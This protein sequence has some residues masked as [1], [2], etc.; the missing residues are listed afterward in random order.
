MPSARRPRVGSKSTGP[1]DSSAGKLDANFS[2]EAWAGSKC[3]ASEVMFRMLQDALLKMQ[4]CKAFSCCKTPS[5]P[6][7]SMRF[8]S[9]DKNLYCSTPE[10]CP[11]NQPALVVCAARLALATMCPEETKDDWAPERAW[12]A[13]CTMRSLLSKSVVNAISCIKSLS[14]EIC[15]AMAL[16]R[17]KRYA[18]GSLSPFLFMQMVEAEMPP[19]LMPTRR[20]RLTKSPFAVPSCFS[21]RV[22]SGTSGINSSGT[23]ER[24]KATSV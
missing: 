21:A 23:R 22:K 3:S 16:P 19:V 10:N 12:L 15:G 4:A 14:S 2:R 5:Q 1:L 6:P 13:S 8:S 7:S 11:D 20:V 24:S 17:M 9:S 18:T